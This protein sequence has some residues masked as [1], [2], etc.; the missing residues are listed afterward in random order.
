VLSTKWSFATVQ[1]T[2]NVLISL[3][4]TIGIWT[5]SRYWYQRSSSK[6]IQERDVALSS[7]FTFTS[8][9]DAWNLLVLLRQKLFTSRYFP[10]LVQLVVVL[11]VTTVTILAGPIARY[12][13]KSE[14]ILVQRPL[15]DLAAGVGTSRLGESNSANVV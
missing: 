5:F 14:T 1:A 6:I 2:L 4:G 10:L 8:P 9:G 3:L 15:P 7:L 13:L 12:S 11:T